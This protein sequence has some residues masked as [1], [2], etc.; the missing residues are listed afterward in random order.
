[1]SKKVVVLLLAILPLFTFTS[2]ELS[3]YET[4][5]IYEYTLDTYK[6]SSYEDFLIEEFFRAKDM[7]IDT[8]YYLEG[9]SETENN[10]E[11]VR[12]FHQELDDVTDR[13]IYNLGVDYDSEFTFSL[14]H[15]SASGY[16]TTLCEFVYPAD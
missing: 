8:Y 4:T 16:R 15:V 7:K 3:T 5:S 11:M 12:Y 14:K 13:D 10:N 1:M 9:Y 6:T 2:C